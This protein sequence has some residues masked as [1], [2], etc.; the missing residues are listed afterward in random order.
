[1]ANSG[2][3]HVVLSGEHALREATRD[4][5]SPL[6]NF[7]DEIILHPL[8]IHSIEELVVRS[9]QQLDI[10]LVEKAEIIE[11][12]FL[13]TSGH[14]NI[15]QRL[16]HRLIE[17]MNQKGLRRITLSLVNEVVNSPLFLRDDFLGT[18]WESASPLE[19][20]ISLIMVESQKPLAAHKIQQLLEKKTRLSP[21]AREVDSSLQRL[22][23]LRAILRHTI[24]G[25]EIANSAFPLAVSRVLTVADMVSVL[26]EECEEQS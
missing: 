18:V 1:M 25:Y 11:T 17:N 9:M 5:H 23:D 21:K 19:K 4:S 16:C 12:I 6:F 7:A 8:E 2:V 15:V 20:I 3:I 14:P 13:F 22:V 24:E 10:E 26:V